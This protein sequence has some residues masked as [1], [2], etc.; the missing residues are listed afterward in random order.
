[1]TP[2]YGR[3]AW[4][5]PR[6]TLVPLRA[7]FCAAGTKWH[8]PRHN[9]RATFE[10]ILQSKSRGWHKWHN[11]TAIKFS[12]RRCRKNDESAKYI[13]LNEI[14]AFLLCRRATRKTANPY[15]GVL[16]NIDY[17]KKGRYDTD[18]VEDL[19]GYVDLMVQNSRKNLK[20]VRRKYATRFVIDDILTSAIKCD[21]CGE[22]KRLELHHVKPLWAIALEIV[23]SNLDHVH[24]NP[25]I[26]F[27]LSPLEIPH[28]AHDESNLKLLCRSCHAQEETPAEQYWRS[29][30]LDRY[31]LV[32]RHKRTIYVSRHVRGGDLIEYYKVK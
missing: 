10:G 24:A 22:R 13:H 21:L 2:I 5:D 9:P 17:C 26:D 8:A 18:S 15:M 12:F 6:A 1:M 19:G 32:F 3:P 30:F 20:A 23:L 29:Y 28:I 4:H 31:P 14:K 7:T 16:M 25:G 27:Y 11:G